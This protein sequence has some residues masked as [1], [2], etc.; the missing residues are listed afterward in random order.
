[1][2]VPSPQAEAG[3]HRCMPVREF[4]PQTGMEGE[5]SPGS[6]GA[7]QLLGQPLLPRLL[8]GEP[9]PFPGGGGEEGG[10]ET[11]PHRSQSPE[12]TPPTQVHSPFHTLGCGTEKAQ[13]GQKQDGQRPDQARPSWPHKMTEK[14]I[15]PPC[16]PSDPDTSMETNREER[17]P[18]GSLPLPTGTETRVHMRTGIQARH[19]CVMQSYLSIHVQTQIRTDKQAQ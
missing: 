3:L 12:T 10:V 9:Q 5:A 16:G 19:T 6:G 13:E 2:I 1:M 8:T 7:V 15:S 14:V 18:R 4:Q 11:P 17:V